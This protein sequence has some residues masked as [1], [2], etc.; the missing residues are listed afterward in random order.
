MD[1]GE[2][3]A[4]LDLDRKKQVCISRKLTIWFMLGL[5]KSHFSNHHKV[6]VFRKKSKF[7]AKKMEQFDNHSRPV[8]IYL[9]LIVIISL[10][11]N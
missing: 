9:S 10:N 1:S 4:P 5:S 8:H 2:Q 3:F 6:R 11:G 7:L